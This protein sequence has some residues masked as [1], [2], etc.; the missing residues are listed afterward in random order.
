MNLAFEETPTS[1]PKGGLGEDSLSIID[2]PLDFPSRRCLLVL[3]W[4]MG[5]GRFTSQ[6]RRTM[7]Q[8]RQVLGPSSSG[9][10][11]LGYHTVLLFP[12]QLLHMDLKYHQLFTKTY[13]YPNSFQIMFGGTL[14]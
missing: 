2:R 12:S 3:I 11:N 7:S 10:K 6:A 8:A 9:F 4:K 14:W 5:L 1:H 13:N